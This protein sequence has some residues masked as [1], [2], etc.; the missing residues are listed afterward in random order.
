MTKYKTPSFQKVYDALLA[1]A[2][3][4]KS[5]LYY[6]GE[7]H[8]GASHRVAFW[9]GFSGKFDLTGRNR[10]A[11]V[12]PGTLSA[13][14]FT[15]GREWA[16]RSAK[17]AKE[18]EAAQKSAQRGGAG[19]NQGRKPKDAGG[20]TMRT[21][22]IRMTDEEWGDAKMVGLDELRTWV[23]DRA[24]ELRAK[25]LNALRAAEKPL[26]ATSLA[27]ALDMPP[28]NTWRL[29]CILETDGWVKA[30]NAKAAG[31]DVMALT[32]EAVTA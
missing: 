19:R 10:S 18:A 16:R 21:R 27:P 25:T 17:A 22:P 26:D 5:E 20:E 1:A 4:Q 3:D 15:A 28:M 13:V 24:A 6:D 30:T 2:A 8:R 23:R 14:A 29:L 31:D 11:N 7:Q 32:F 12:V 9:D